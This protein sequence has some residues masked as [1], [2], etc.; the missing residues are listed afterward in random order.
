[1]V[2]YIAGHTG[3]V[4]SALVRRF[5]GRAGIRTLTATR[6][7]LDLTDGSSVHEFLK[8]ER[9][10]VVIIAAGK[11]G[12][13][14]A[15]SRVPAD[16]IYENLMIEANLIH[17]A[18]QTGVKR[19]LNFG[20]SCMYP[21]ACSQPMTTEQLMTGA[22]EP[23]SQPYAVAKWAGMTLCSAYHRQHGVAFLTA[24]PC[25][26]Y[27]PGDSFDPDSAHVLSA[28]I[29]KFHEARLR[30]E[31]R[32]ILWGTG[33][34]Q[35]EFI[36]AEDLAEACDVLLE[37][38]RGEEPINVGSGQAQRVRELAEI[39]KAIV[40]FEGDI[41]WDRSRPDGAPEKRLDSSLIHGFGWSARTPLRAG[42]EQT[43]HWFLEHEA[44][45]IGREAPCISS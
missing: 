20:S 39:V 13:I 26:V 31:R 43:Y 2:V 35:R 11:V 33:A 29:R 25:T 16:F 28:L 40:G 44:A 36:Y 42:V 19:L 21:K 22:V 5:S 45:A 32:V 15:N 4:G 10:D 1:M 23:T 9:P 34:P 14:L 18:W 17:G 38:Y 41:H 12:G 6:S 27:G 30:A 7:E 3:L 37:R 24:I 8:R